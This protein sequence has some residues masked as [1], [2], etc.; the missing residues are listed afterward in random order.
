VRLSEHKLYIF[1]DEYDASMNETLK[2][3]PIF[4]DLTNHKK[5]G[6]SVKSKIELIESSFKQ[7]YSRLK[8]A[9]DKGLPMFFKLA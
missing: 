5:E 3:K 6:D 2:N 9:C 4:Q 8:T 7:F 1:I